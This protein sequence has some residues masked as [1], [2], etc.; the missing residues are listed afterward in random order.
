MINKHQ[1]L[2]DAFSALIIGLVLALLLL[3]VSLL[4]TGCFTI[5]GTSLTLSLINTG[6]PSTVIDTEGVSSTT[7]GNSPDLGLPGLSDAGIGSLSEQIQREKQRR[8]Y[9]ALNPPDR[10]PRTS[11]VI[12]KP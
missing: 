12:E 2:P 8:I 9:E 11:A 7:T 5:T 4:V 6:A 3:V 10:A 1:Q